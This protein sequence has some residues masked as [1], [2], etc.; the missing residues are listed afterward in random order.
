LAPVQIEN[1]S[2]YLG[3][4]NIMAKVTSSRDRSKGKTKTPVRSDKGRPNRSSTSTASVSTGSNG[5]PPARGARVTNASQRATT[6]STRVTGT[7][8]AARPA[9]PP[10]KGGAIVRSPGGALTAPRS[11]GSGSSTLPGRPSAARLPGGTG[12]AD[13][14]RGSGVRTGRPGAARP[15]LP[16]AARPSA[17]ATPA[18]GASTATT[19][20][21]TSA[22]RGL[23]GKL[24][25]PLAIGLQLADVAGGFGKLAAH[26]LLNKNKGKFDAGDRRT[27]LPGGGSKPKRGVTAANYEN[28][29]HTGAGRGN[30]GLD[31]K[32]PAAPQ[33]PPPDSAPRPSRSS[34]GS[35]SASR[36]ARSA[37]STQPTAAAA[38]GR[39]WED[40]NPNRG[41]SKSNNPLLDRQVGG[42]SL[43]DRMKERENRGGM[44]NFNTNVDLKVDS[45]KSEDY[46][47]ATPSNQTSTAYTAKSLIEEQRKK[48]NK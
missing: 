41:T 8:T 35:S 28:L 34:G 40:F 1:N 36:P 33:L 25:V 15:G 7:P 14:V 42:S 5:K 10:S 48:K 43:R 26:P 37:A 46:S 20:A 32:P 13:T 45:P 47:K 29:Y 24:A 39:K 2:F 23:L 4:I 17:A 21:A 18:K 19:R 9:L 38:P 6:G 30:Y 12:G 3:S 22:G 27:N 31:R 11:S 16:P 44:K